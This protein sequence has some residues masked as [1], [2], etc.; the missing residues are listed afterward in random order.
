MKIFLTRSEKN[1]GS[2]ITVKT[3]SN[4]T[5]IIL[6]TWGSALNYHPHLHTIVLGG[7]LEVFRYLGK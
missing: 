1:V 6:H 4:N 3:L 2:V 7:G 5:F